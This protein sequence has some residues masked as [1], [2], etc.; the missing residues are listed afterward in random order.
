V[1]CHDVV[2]DRSQSSIG[3][4]EGADT[5]NHRYTGRLQHDVPSGLSMAEIGGAHDSSCQPEGRHCKILPAV[6]P[7][8]AL[9]LSGRHRCDDSAWR[10]V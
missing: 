8:I 2:A 4:T 1:G 10:N 9:A 6:P 3:P 7:H 5:T